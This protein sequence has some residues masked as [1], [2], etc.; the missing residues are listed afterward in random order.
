[1]EVPGT[2]PATSWS[3]VRKLAPRPVIVAYSYI[4]KIK[5]AKVHILVLHRYLFSLKEGNLIVSVS[6][7]EDWRLNYANY[8]IYIFILERLYYISED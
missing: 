2:E 1:M 4:N 5:L 3:V 7:Y 8:F 6:L